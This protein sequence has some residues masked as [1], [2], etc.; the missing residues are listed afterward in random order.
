MENI[1]EYRKR[2]FSNRA[3]NK[4]SN[5]TPNKTYYNRGIKQPNLT[6]NKKEN[7]KLICDELTKFPYENI[8]GSF[9][10]VFFQKCDEEYMNSN[11]N[12]KFFC[13]KK[14]E[15]NKFTEKLKTTKQ[16]S[17]KEYNYIKELSISKG[18]FLTSEN[19]RILY[20]KI[21]LLNN[22]NTDKMLYIDHEA[23]IDKNWDYEC[24][25]IL[26]EKKIYADFAESK[27]N[28]NIIHSDCIN[29]KVPHIFSNNKDI[30][31]MFNSDLEAYIKTMMSLNN[32]IYSYFSGYQKIGLYFLL[33]Y[34]RNS[35]YA[36]S[37]FQRFSEFNLKELLTTNHKSKNCFDFI[38]TLKILKFIINYIDPI[39]QNFL[40]KNY[41]DG[42]CIFAAK[43]IISLFTYEFND[44]LNKIYR[45]F[46]YLIINHP[47]AIYFLSAKI[48]CDYYHKIE[49]EKDDKIL[50]FQ[51]I[52]LKLFDLD[53]YIE[54]SDLLLKNALGDY[55][56]SELSMELK[57][58]KFSPL[59]NEQ[60]FS[61]K[62][63]K[64][65]NQNELKNNIWYNIK[66][67]WK[68]FTNIFDSK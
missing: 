53:E 9:I 34:Y 37:I 3:N 48:I 62:W 38:D 46:D 59:I 51:N 66:G 5:K 50:F 23:Q 8:Y 45:L 47:L 60:A 14:L 32:N 39:C 22:L 18:G 1:E 30:S 36:I 63:V 33:L 41:I 54:K 29:T 15:L 13:N 31:N 64:V 55:K 40:D 12:K 52:D 4:I 43:W 67:Q 21:Y 10:E 42:L 68:M 27:N 25:D 35:N 26:S 16:I 6:P 65:K 20:K 56:F 7:N 19:R 44:D 17:I 2:K 57:L 58:D 28:G 49:T 11:K 24:I 61:E